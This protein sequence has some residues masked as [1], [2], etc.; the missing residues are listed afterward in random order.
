MHGESSRRVEARSDRERVA[1]KV[2]L[3]VIEGKPLGAEVPIPGRR[4]LIGRDRS[5]GL[6]PKHPLVSGRQ[7][8]IL[9]QGPHVLV[10]DLGS[11]NGTL[12]NEHCLQAGEAQRVADGDRLQVG[13]LI[14]SIRIADDLEAGSEPVAESRSSSA[15]LEVERWL[16]GSADSEPVESSEFRATVPAPGS[17]PSV[18]EDSWSG[19][20]ASAKP[21]G[22]GLEM[23]KAKDLAAI[24]PFAYRRFDEERGVLR[25]GLGSSQ[26][27]DE[28]R[29]VALRSALFG[30]IAQ[31]RFR[32]L[33][34]DLGQIEVVPSL[35]IAL[36]LSTARRCRAK[37]GELRICSLSF[38][39]D[40]LVARLGIDRVVR[41]YA[42]PIEA[43]D[44]PW[45]GSP[46]GNGY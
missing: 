6:R 7:C 14:F 4:F 37:G 2:K 42:D 46:N 45:T 41:C 22:N 33:V 13:R 40:R 9:R 3:V 24:A 29:I 36:L 10:R 38:E 43:R 17:E 21:P 18:S 35:G 8:E 1:S 20:R 25:I 34:L 26:M 12:V 30:L 19:C 11:V 16:L 23:E 27:I 32:R 28:E 39:V 5:C 31:P 44:D 15:E